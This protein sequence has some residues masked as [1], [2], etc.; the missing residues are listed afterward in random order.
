MKCIKVSIW[1]LIALVLMT[2]TAMGNSN[3]TM[4]A[5]TDKEEYHW[6]DLVTITLTIKNIG[7]TDINNLRILNDED[8]YHNVLCGYGSIINKINIS[9]GDTLNITDI[10]GSCDPNG[11]IENNPNPPWISYINY[12]AGYENLDSI[13]NNAI[14]ST[15]VPIIVVNKE[16]NNVPEFPTVALPAIAIMGMIFLLHR[17]KAD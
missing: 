13:G 16:T 1:C 7:N 14:S 8:G 4:S 6:S 12:F 2:S 3:I 11:I 5:T 10:R 17:R 15:S 9:A